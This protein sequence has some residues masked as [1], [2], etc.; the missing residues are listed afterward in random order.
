MN[1][2]YSPS[3]TVRSSPFPL[4]MRGLGAIQWHLGQDDGPI[5]FSDVTPI[6]TSM[7]DPGGTLID[8]TTGSGGGFDFLPSIPAV[9]PIDT[10][11]YD[12]SG[13]LVPPASVSPQTAALAQLY[14]S[15]VA[16]GTM[17]QSQANSQI[18]QLITAAASTA[19]A[20]QGLTTAPSPRVAVPAVPGA[21]ASILS[22]QSI[23][24][25]VPDIAI[26]GAA[27]LAVFAMS[28]KK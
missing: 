20:A 19:K 15:S 4:Y 3:P 11:M 7:Y 23:I 25:G 14:K 16:A 10:T 2:M 12:P 13:N 9:T 22:S 28:V 27:L 5:L 24:K 17:T 18:A 1:R 26:L 8:P 6:D 21:G